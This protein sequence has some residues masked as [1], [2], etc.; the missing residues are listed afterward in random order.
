MQ[1]SKKPQHP[2]SIQIEYSNRTAALK[3]KVEIQS[4][5][6]T[7][8]TGEIKRTLIVLAIPAIYIALSA[9]L[10]LHPG[11]LPL[12]FIALILIILAISRI[13]QSPDIIVAATIIYI[14]LSREYPAKLAAGINGTTAIELLLLASVFYYSII[15]KEKVNRSRTLL[16]KITLYW[17]LT[18]LISILTA[19]YSIGFHE[20]IWNYTYAVRAFFDQIILF[21]LL[22]KLIN[23]N[24]RARRAFVY[25]LYSTTIVLI[26]GFNE[27]L[28]SRN[29]ASIEKSRLLGP[30]LQ[31][32]EFAAQLIYTFP[33]LLATAFFYFP[34]ISSWKYIFILPFAIRVLL[35][36][37]SR[38]AYLAFAAEFIT[39]SFFK[40]KKFFVLVIIA[41]A[42]IYLF[43]PA[44]VPNS[45]KARVSQTFHDTGPDATIDK[46]A[47]S[48]FY[49]WDAAIKMT[50]QNP[51][52][53]MGF[54]QF[55]RLSSL[56]TEIPIEATDNQNMFLYAASNM[57]LPS[58]ILLIILLLIFF[59]LSLKIYK[60]SDVPL[61]KI[62]GL[63]GA[64]MIPG[65][66]VVNM[67][68][69]HMIDPSVSIFFWAYMAI[70]LG[71]R[72]PANNSTDVKGTVAI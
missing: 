50:K 13:R 2:R 55:H 53:G 31:P 6:N 40:S 59:F 29:L 42:S 37:F 71:I 11:R 23:S 10:H 44:L 15:K 45:L 4:V 18:A 49:L 28:F 47:E 14:P 33:A 5:N 21:F 20:F 62:I 60:K 9:V 30:V 43:V 70:L 64:S 3:N 26:I 69:T 39:L 57:G 7:E 17:A 19:M 35:A 51:V 58:L 32:N 38:G 63:G 12:Y 1:D 48:R 25:L 41:I 46:S 34:K 66:I 54:D 61:E 22:Y 67:F 16:P 68:G 36:T 52:F 27:W 65:F 24:S 72:L 56:Y 8:N